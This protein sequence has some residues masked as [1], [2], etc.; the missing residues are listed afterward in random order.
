MLRSLIAA[1][2]SGL[3]RQRFQAHLSRKEVERIMCIL[4]SAIIEYTKPPP[5]PTLRCSFS[6]PHSSGTAARYELAD[7]YMT[8]L[9]LAKVDH[10]I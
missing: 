3:S 10:D 8:E 9:G 1:I 7:M 6:S 4:E 5:T 2:P